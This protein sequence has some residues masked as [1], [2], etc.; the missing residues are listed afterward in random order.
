MI[1]CTQRLP[2]STEKDRETET[3]RQTQTDIQRDRVCKNGICARL[4]EKTTVNL[5]NMQLFKALNDFLLPLL[6]MLLL[7]LL[8]CYL[9]VLFCFLFFF[10]FS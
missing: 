3:D 5:K 8:F 6:L 10:F 9:S 4:R 1:H 7:L 2:G